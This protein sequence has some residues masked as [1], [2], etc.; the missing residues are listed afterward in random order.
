MTRNS[1]EFCGQ[2]RRE[3]LWQMGG[4]FVGTALTYLLARDGFF[5]RA[6]YSAANATDSPLSPKPAH[7]A[8]RAKACIFIFNYG[9]PSQVD[10]WDPKPALAKYNGQPIP[11]L[12]NDPLL[13]VRKPGTLLASSRKFTKAGQCGVEVS[14]LWPHLAGCID[15]LAIFRSSFL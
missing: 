4:G 10:L 6:D 1:K 3:L 9:G 8:A 7:F 11:N 14:D 2:T 5:A 13:K 12:D 15:E